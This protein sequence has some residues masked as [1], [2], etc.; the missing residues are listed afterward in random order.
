LKNMCEKFLKDVWNDLSQYERVQPIEEM[1]S[2]NWMKITELML[3]FSSE[4]F[5]IRRWR[6]FI[7]CTRAIMSDWLGDWMM[8]WLIDWLTGMFNWI[9]QLWR[10]YHI[11]E[12]IQHHKLS[13]DDQK[14]DFWH[15]L[16]FLNG[17]TTDR[18]RM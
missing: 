12:F 5:E 3:I 2:L 17:E 9:P 16:R 1:K 15:N 18:C 10:T 6:V 4:Q 13:R 8:Y 11:L 7:P 14:S